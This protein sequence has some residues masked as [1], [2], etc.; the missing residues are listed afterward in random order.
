MYHIALILL[1]IGVV[2]EFKKGKT[3]HK[4]FY[5]AFLLLTLMLSLRYGQG[6]DYFSYRLMY[7][8]TPSNFF[9][10]FTYYG[11]EAEYG[12]RVVFWVF[13]L[14]GQPFPAFIFVLS[15]AEMALLFR[16]IQRFC[17]RRM[18]ALFLCYH[19]LYLTWL[20]SGLRQGLVM[21]VFLGLLLEWLLQKKYLPY[22]I[23]CVLCG[24]IHGVGF[25][26]LTAVIVNTKLLQTLKWQLVLV[27]AAWAFGL[28]IATGIFDGFLPKILPESV[29][30]YYSR[31]GLSFFAI[32]ERIFSYAVT[33]YM[34]WVC[35]GGKGASKDRMRRLM[36]LV[37]LGMVVYGGFVWLP[38]VASR[39]AVLFKMVEIAIWSSLL[40]NRDLL[41]KL[42]IALC[43]CLVF[44]MYTKNLNSYI[45]EG[46]YNEHVNVIN[47]PY[48]SVFDTKE[49]T[50]YRSLD[51]KYGP[52]AAASIDLFE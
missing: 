43:I 38:L 4:Y 23:G 16:F 28:L 5:G 2:Y 29:A 30:A 46:Q 13:R 24:C 21:V 42:K 8:M 51:A 3:P 25:L 26:L 17:K 39:L 31:K 18:L 36:Q 45:S 37:T 33:V 1:L 19:T 14:F 47:F 10:L 20:F 44:V 34:F 27:G 49:I 11:F 12:W 40:L 32:A 22:C 35:S 41:G 9:K 50:Q 52:L 48:V 7:D 15:I 6:T